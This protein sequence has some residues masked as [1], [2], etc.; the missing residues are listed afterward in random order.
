VRLRRA[1]ASVLD[2]RAM[3]GVWNEPASTRLVPDGVLPRSALPP[4]AGSA[5]GGGRSASLYMCGDPGGNR[6]GEIIRANLRTIGIRVRIDN[7]L[8]CLRGPDPARQRADMALETLASFDLDPKIFL[9]A[10]AGDDRALGDPVPAGWAP[11]ALRARIAR[12]DRLQGA[13]RRRAFTALETRMARDD[14]P[15]A[16]FG[17]FVAPEYISPHVGCRLFQGAYGFLDLGAACLS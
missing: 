14:V 12:A 16:G 4:P 13:A 17:E 10:V 6:I 15:M 2:R 8:G 7:S 11:P 3:A 9:S 1:A 5:R